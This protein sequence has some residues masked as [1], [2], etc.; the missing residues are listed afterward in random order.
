M[1]MLR[2]FLM[3]SELLSSFITSPERVPY[4]FLWNENGCKILKSTQSTS[5]TGEVFLE[6]F[7]YS[8]IVLY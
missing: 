2:F 7:K 8:L 1:N 6:G 3:L 5:N 4:M